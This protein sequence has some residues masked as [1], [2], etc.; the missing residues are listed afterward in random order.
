MGCLSE[1]GT[2]A[3]QV[4]SERDVE[5]VRTLETGVKSYHGTV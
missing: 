5:I 1:E 4:T 3:E 2:W